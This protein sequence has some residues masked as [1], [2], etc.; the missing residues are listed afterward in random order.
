LHKKNYVGKTITINRKDHKE[1]KGNNKKILFVNPLCPLRLCA[2]AVQKNP[3]TLAF[4][5]LFF[6]LAYF[7]AEKAH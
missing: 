5:L 1:R 6:G 4:L 7:L 2:F 3:E